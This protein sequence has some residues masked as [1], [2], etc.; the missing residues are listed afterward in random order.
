MMSGRLQWADFMVCLPGR[1]TRRSAPLKPAPQ[2][3]MK[4]PDP[5]EE[6][7]DALSE[8]RKTGKDACPTL[9][10]FLTNRSNL[11]AAK[12]A[13]IAGEVR[14]EELVPDLAAA[15]HRLM[16]NPAKL[17]K[18]CAAVTAIV[19][20][21]YSMDYES[22]DVYLAGVRHV[23]MEASYGPPVDAAAQLRADCALGLARTRHPDALFEVVRLLADKEPKVRM[24]AAR[25]LGSVVGEAGELL[26]LLKTLTGDEEAEVLGECF[27]GM[28]SSGMER[29]LAVVASYVDH[30]DQAIAE[31]AI[32]ALG[33]SRMPGAIDVLKNKWGRAVGPVRKTLLL[34]L[35]TAPQDAA[36]EF[37]LSVVR[38]GGKQGAKEVVDALRAYRNDERV[39][40][41][42]EKAGGGAG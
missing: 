8:L 33:A 26:L 1:Q 41:A 21:L 24:G 19:E 37:L 30:D 34:A 35:A 4:K 29:S 17:D 23:Q 40:R 28:L 12:A 11:V 6:A 5:V 9:R 18:G 27:A 22:A 36:I 39:Q 20:A 10:R 2:R 7:L 14:I 13:K 32:L 25:A 42:L 38:E 16:T 3:A 31:A 15:F